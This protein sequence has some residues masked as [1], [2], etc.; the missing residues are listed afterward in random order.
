MEGFN[1]LFFSL[2]TSCSVFRWCSMWLAQRNIWGNKV[3]FWWKLLVCYFPKSVLTFFP[4]KGSLKWTRRFPYV[5][6]PEDLSLLDCAIT[7]QHTMKLLLWWWSW[8][9]GYLWL[10]WFS[11]TVSLLKKSL[12]SPN[13]KSCWLWFMTFSW[14]FIM[15]LFSK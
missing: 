9:Q 1:Q 12:W 5:C 8:W 14:D 15:F 13:V 7:R 4:S 10:I 3:A 6:N 2:L 11:W